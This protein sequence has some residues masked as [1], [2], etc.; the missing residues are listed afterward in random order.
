MIQQVPRTHPSMLIQSP[1]ENRWHRPEITLVQQA[2]ATA[3]PVCN[4]SE[5]QYYNAFPL[6]N[7]AREKPTMLIPARSVSVFRIRTTRTASP[8]PR[9]D[10]R[11]L[12]GAQT[13][14]DA[15]Q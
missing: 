2:Q 5:G 12:G 11:P 10:V 9:L 7:V 4:A 13:V 6:V 1:P 14:A 8:T 3:T 15:I